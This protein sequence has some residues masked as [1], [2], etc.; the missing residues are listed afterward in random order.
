MGAIVSR[1]AA[2]PASAPVWI[3]IGAAVPVMGTPSAMTG[4]PFT[5]LERVAV[6]AIET[7]RGWFWKSVTPLSV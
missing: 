2:L 4:A 6:G 7:T 1:N 5:P 3:A